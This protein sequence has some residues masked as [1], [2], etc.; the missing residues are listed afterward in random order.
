MEIPQS[1]P[2]IKLEKIMIPLVCFP[3]SIKIQ[4]HVMRLSPTFPSG[5][6]LYQ[7]QAFQRLL[8][9]FS[10][11]FP[12]HLRNIFL[13]HV[14]MICLILRTMPVVALTHTNPLMSLGVFSFSFCFG[15]RVEEG[16]N[17]VFFWDITDETLPSYIKQSTQQRGKA[18][19][20][21]EELEAQQPK[22]CHKGA[23]EQIISVVKS[24]N[25]LG[26]LLWKSQSPPGLVSDW[27]I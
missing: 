20:K 24:L 23:K 22:G 7:P 26:L 18:R 6:S 8:D 12:V 1:S 11:W 21:K 15:E 16:C 10:S 2:R 14:M 19:T 3:H 17:L 27:M 9:P 5:V 13:G 4:I 25:G